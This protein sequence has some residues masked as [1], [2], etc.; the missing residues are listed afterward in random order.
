M[1]PA[2]EA[3]RLRTAHCRTDKADRDAPLLTTNSRRIR[4][5]HAAVSG[6]AWLT[7]DSLTKR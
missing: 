5:I 2:R 7:R 1:L 6:Q 3:R 4:H